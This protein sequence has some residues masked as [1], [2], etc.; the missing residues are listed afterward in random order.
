MMEPAH[1]EETDGQ[2]MGNQ[3]AVF[4]KIGLGE[5]AMERSEQIIDTVV[6]IRSSFA[7]RKTIIEDAVFPSFP[8]NFVEILVT[9]EV[10]PFLFPQTGFF[11]VSELLPWKCCK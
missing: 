10:S 9:T 2:G 7:T 1:D 5:I 4:R 3:D 6:Y 11:V 8:T